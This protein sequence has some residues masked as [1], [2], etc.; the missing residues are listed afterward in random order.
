MCA[1]A[2]KFGIA[3]IVDV[4]PNHTTTHKDEISLDF[5]EAVGG[6]EKMYHKNSDHTIRSMANRREVTSAMLGGLPDVNTEN[7]LF[8]EYFMNYINDL[9]D[10]GADGFR[11]DTAKHIALP[12]DPVDPASKENDFW[13]IF[14]GK[15]Q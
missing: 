10:C 4:V 7:P 13:P 12:D 2:K 9:I 1:K 15:N 11:F 5:I 6:M 3:V 14:T 8:Q